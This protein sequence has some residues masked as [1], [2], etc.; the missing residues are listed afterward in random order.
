MN[1]QAFTSVHEALRAAG[2]ENTRRLLTTVSAVLSDEEIVALAEVLGGSTT[3]GKAAVEFVN[4]L[5]AH[6]SQRLVGIAIGRHLY[7]RSRKSNGG[8]GLSSRAGQVLMALGWAK[9][10]SFL[11]A[12]FTSDTDDLLSD[13][14][15]QKLGDE[16]DDELASLRDTIQIEVPEAGK[17]FER[18]AAARARKVLDQFVQLADLVPD[19]VF[20]FLP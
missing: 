3:S 16:F 9:A 17:V 8:L 6:E 5:G 4:S 19:W 13:S 10:Q 15:F 18:M 1:R 20:R 2:T 12:L 7:R 11:S 14:E